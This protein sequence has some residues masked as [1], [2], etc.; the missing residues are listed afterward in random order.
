[1]WCNVNYLRARCG[2]QVGGCW[3][4]FYSYL[5]QIICVVIWLNWIT[6][7]RKSGK[8][9]VRHTE[10]LDSYFNLI[11]SLLQCIPW[12]SPF[13][14]YFLV[15]EVTIMWMHISNLERRGPEDERVY[16]KSTDV[17]T[18]HIRSRGHIFTL[19]SKFV[20][21]SER[22]GP[23]VSGRVSALYSVV[24]GSISCGEDHSIHYW[25]DLIRSK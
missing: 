8:Q 7:I 18:R 23:M 3:P 25:W 24:T 9:C 10:T 11:T 22:C 12:T 6:M 5:I 17:T 2:L 13:Y 21:A 19:T 15:H 4:V 1:M 16:W 20:N 14:I